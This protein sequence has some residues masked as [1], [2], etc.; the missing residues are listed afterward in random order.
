MC[1]SVCTRD[2]VLA[3]SRTK[4]SLRAAIFSRSA[5]FSI[6]SCS[7]S[8]RDSPAA[9]SSLS[10]TFSSVRASRRRNLA[11]VTRSRLTIASAARSFPSRDS[12]ASS[13]NPLPGLPGYSAALAT[14][15]LYVSNAT[16]V[17]S[18]FADRASRSA[19]TS[20]HV[21]A[22]PSAASAIAS[23]ARRQPADA[24]AYPILLCAAS[25]S[26][27]S[28]IAAPPPPPS[29]PSEYRVLARERCAA[30]ARSS[31]AFLPANSRRDI[32]SASSS[33]IRWSS[34]GGRSSR[35]DDASGRAVS[36]PGA[37]ASWISSAS[38]P[39]SRSDPSVFMDSSTSSSTRASTEEPADDGAPR[40]NDPSRVR[41]SH[42]S[43]SG[44]SGSSSASPAPPSSSPAGSSSALLKDAS[45]SST[46]FT[47]S[48]NPGPSPSDSDAPS[49]IPLSA[50]TRASTSR[51]SASR[52]RA[53]RPTRK[54]SSRARGSSSEI[55]KWDPHPVAFS[56]P[57]SAR[58][59]ASRRSLARPDDAARALTA[60]RAAASSSTLRPS[61]RR[62]GH[63][64]SSSSP[65]NR[66]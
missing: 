36:V 2:P 53:A 6:L 60:S 26:F 14:S 13:D 32:S 49:H 42:S 37:G 47:S 35:G 66:R 48:E 44:S 12:T 7:K 5:P 21:A 3:R 10:R 64:L 30:R 55:F 41:V 51:T 43:A 9:S 40:V 45:D 20:A 39:R 58:S 46:S 61:A 17:A 50:S 29:A 56:S 34:S 63:G 24:L 16:T 27:A 59:R 8:T 18:R 23:R 38:G 15:A 62:H 28:A 1:V 31:S 65:A 4:S 22:C 54:P 52:L 33:S 19:R 25:G 11:F 57:G